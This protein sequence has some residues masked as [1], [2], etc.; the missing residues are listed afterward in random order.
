MYTIYSKTPYL[1]SFLHRQLVMFQALM[2]SSPDLL[3]G[4]GV[5]PQAI[6]AAVQQQEAIENLRV[7]KFHG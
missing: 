1:L 5:S 6:T 2:Q 3:V 7:S 4:L